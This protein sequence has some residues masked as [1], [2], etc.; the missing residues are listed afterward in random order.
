VGEQGLPH[1][2]EILMKESRERVR[3]AATTRLLARQDGDQVPIGLPLTVDLLKRGLPLLLDAAFEDE[4]LSVRF[5]ALLRVDGDSPLGGFHYVPVSS[6]RPREVDHDLRMLL[7]LHGVIL[8][9]VQGKEPATA[10]LFHGRGCQERKVKLACVVGQA[11][12]LLQEIREARTG[13]PPGLV[14]NSHC[15]VCEF[16]QRCQAEA[17]T[18]DDLSLLRGMTEKEIKKYVKRVCSLSHS[19]RT[20]SEPEGGRPPGQQKQ[21][22]LARL[23]G[24][25]HQGEGSHVPWHARTADRPPASTS[26][27]RAILTAASTTCWPQR[28]GRRRGTAAL[29]WADS[30]ADEPHLA[31]VPRSCGKYFRRLALHLRKL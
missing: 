11:R 16:R 20:P 15:Q 8:S 1:D 19:C 17:T 31:A 27:S 4:D 30:P 5:D 25:G 13:P 2:Y 9:G 29:V 18:K 21:V 22:H 10:V 28:G 24:V 7:A 12:R 14:L 23:A 6:T 3:Q 26:T